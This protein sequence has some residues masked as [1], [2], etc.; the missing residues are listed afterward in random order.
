MDG[1]PYCTDFNPVWDSLQENYP[2]INM[3]KVERYDDPSL[4]SKF[5]VS[6]YPK[7]IL[8]KDNIPIEFNDNRTPDLFRDFFKKN[9]L[10]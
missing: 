4:I 2:Q 1:C 6:S 7:I 5:N 10:I 3:K 8:F 9:K